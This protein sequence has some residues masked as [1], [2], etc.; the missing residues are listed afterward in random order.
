MI[1]QYYDWPVF[2]SINK[3]KPAW[4]VVVAIGNRTSP[5]LGVF[6]AQ[7]HQAW[8]ENYP[9]IM[10][11]NIGL[12]G[13]NRG[14][15]NYSILIMLNSKKTIHFRYQGSIVIVH[16]STKPS[17]TLAH[18][19]LSKPSMTL[20]FP[21]SRNHHERHVHRRCW[22]RTGGRLLVVSIAGVRHFTQFLL[23][24][25]ALASAK[26]LMDSLGVGKWENRPGKASQSWRL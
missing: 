10:I 18:P 1:D 15:L 20:G 4:A 17:I 12:E 2:S 7:P 14:P 19:S 23:E 3:Y 5:N 21:M 16:N 22:E 24:R 6:S 11:I 25:L 13:Q 8:Y 26:W 9:R